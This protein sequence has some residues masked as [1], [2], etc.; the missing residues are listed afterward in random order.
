MEE[1]YLQIRTIH[2]WS[3]T[4]QREQQAAGGRENA[5]VRRGLLFEFP[6]DLGGG[7]VD[8]L[9]DAK[10]LLSEHVARAAAFEVFACLVVAL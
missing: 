4:A 3:V 6:A 7:R 1:F 8:C 2:I 9:H 10:R 5:C